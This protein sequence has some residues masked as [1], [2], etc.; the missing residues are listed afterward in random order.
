MMK[1]IQAMKTLINTTKAKPFIH[2][3]RNPNRKT[4]GSFLLSD[5]PDP[6]EKGEDDQ[7]LNGLV[8][9]ECDVNEAFFVDGVASGFHK[10]IDR[11]CLTE[12]E[13]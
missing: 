3:D 13:F 9:A 10:I 6:F 12:D 7:D 8:V 5:H 1:G 2:E 11:A 4:F